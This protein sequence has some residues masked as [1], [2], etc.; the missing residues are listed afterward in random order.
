MTLEWLPRDNKTRDHAPVSGRF[1]GKEPPCTSYDKKPILDGQGNEVPGLYAAW[2]TFNN[3]DQHNAYTVDMIKGA[4]GGFCSASNDRSV[5]VTVV[6]G[7]GTR[8]FC[9][10]GNM[11]DFSEYYAKRP[12]E[13]GEYAA[14]HMRMVDAILDCQKPVI[15]RVNGV[16][17]GGGQDIGMACD[18]SVSSDLATFG[19]LG[20]ERGLASVAGS[21]D[22]LPWFLSAEDAM[23]SCIFSDM[24][25]AYKMKRKN[26]LTTVVPVLRKDGKYIRNPLVYTDTYTKDGEIVYGEPRDHA[27][28]VAGNELIKSCDIDFGLL[29]GEMNRMIWTLVNLFPDSLQMSID[30]IREKKKFFW[31]QS[32]LSKRHWLAANMMGVIP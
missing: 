27:D 28:L 9:T 2:V 30:S 23:G 1:W 10:G 25:S 12:H 4:I 8:A 5:V 31:D 7:A 20:P 14:L 16:R 21:S 19:Q 15:C 3:P 11:K 26:L 13:F 32:K 18:L 17:V 29:D 24:W 6:T 22:F